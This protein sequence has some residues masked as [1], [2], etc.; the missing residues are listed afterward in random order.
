MTIFFDETVIFLQKEDLFL[1]RLVKEITL[2]E[3]KWDK[4]SNAYKS[5]LVYF[6]DGNDFIILKNLYGKINP[7]YYPFFA[8]III[9]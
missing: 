2:F 8:N 3:F 7:Q 1:P 9:K 5:N 4:I 6:F